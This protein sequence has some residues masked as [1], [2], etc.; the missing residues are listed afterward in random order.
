MHHLLTMV[1]N[2]LPNSYNPEF[3]SHSLPVI[4]PATCQ[5]DFL[6]LQYLII[7]LMDESKESFN[8]SAERKYLVHSISVILE[9]NKRYLVLASST[10]HPSHTKTFPSGVEHGTWEDRFHQRTQNCSVVL[11][12]CS[13]RP[14]K[15]AW[16][17][18]DSHSKDTIWLWSELRLL[19]VSWTI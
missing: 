2:K 19:T 13:L 8:G 5:K 7:S 12:G 4:E 14:F 15:K 9:P 1:T 18:R 10:W 3:L 16:P 6:T 17:W 11:Q